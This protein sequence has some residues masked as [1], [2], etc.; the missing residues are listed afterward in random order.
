MH[1]RIVSY[2]WSSSPENTF[3]PIAFRKEGREKERGREREERLVASHVHLDQGLYPPE[4]GLQPAT[5]VRALAR[6]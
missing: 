6:N 2:F 5:Y 3:F 1:V 4:A